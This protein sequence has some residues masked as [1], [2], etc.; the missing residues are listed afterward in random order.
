[1]DISRNFRFIDR[2]D[3]WSHA[4]PSMGSKWDCDE[5]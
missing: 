4:S 2:I 3:S 1:V 5:T